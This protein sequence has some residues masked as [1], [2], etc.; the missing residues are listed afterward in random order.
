MA[1]SQAGAAAPVARTEM[2]ATRRIILFSMALAALASLLLLVVA[3][4]TPAISDTRVAWPLLALGFALADSF[5]VHVEVRD[6]AHSFTM[7]ELPLMIGLFLCNADQL[8]LARVVG[9]VVALVVVRRQRPLKALFNLALSVLETAAALLVFLLVVNAVGHAT[10]A[11]AWVAAILAAVVVNLLQSAAI[12]T[13][14]RLA[15]GPGAPGM[16][17]R[18]AVIGL[19]TAVTTASLGIITVIVIETDVAGV[20]LIG[21]I[22]GLMFAAYRGY[23][24]QSQRYANLEKLYELTRKLANSPDLEDSMRVTLQEARQLVRSEESELVLFQGVDDTG[25]AVLVRLTSSGELQMSSD[26][27]GGDDSVRASVVATRNGVVIPRTTHD[28]A[29]RAYL[30]QRGLVDLVTVPVFQGGVIVGTLA[31]HNRLGDVSSFDEEDAKVF[32]TLAHHVGTAIENARLIER[33]RTEV[34]QKEYQSLHDTLTGLGN[35]D[36]FVARTDDALRASRT[37][38]WSVAVMLMDLNR[39]K[40]V[41][42]TL[43]HHH[44]DLLLQQVARRIGTVLPEPGMIARLGGDEFV[45]LLPQIRNQE[46]AEQIAI[47]IQ[48]ALQQ[49]F[50]VD[51]MQLAVTAAIGIAVAPAHGTE[52]STLLQHADIAMYNAKEHGDG[53]V[54]VYD[55]DQNRHSTRRLTLAAELQTAIADGD[56]EV[57]YQ[58]KAVLETG[59]LVGVEALVRWEHPKH[60]PIPPDEFVPLAEGTGQ[61]RAMTTLVV[62]RVLQQ[63]GAWRDAGVD[64]QVSVNLSVRSLIDLDFASQI[65]ALCRARGVDPSALVLEITET[66][67][68]ADPTR[69]IRMLERLASLGIEISVDDFGTGYSSLSYLQRLP[70]HEIKVDK[71]FV[72]GMTADDAN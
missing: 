3:Q 49:P 39:F 28:L 10:G 34:S 16:A 66:Q 40:D 15:G 64:L 7:N 45:V 51:R 48:A 8:V 6:N 52:V 30:Q 57:Y 43:G 12:T 5:A 47:G 59:A 29:Q 11:G 65:D 23:A 50:V 54:E 36:L 53:G 27:L 42:D 55:P 18:M 20:F 56:L 26:E 41:N 63:V 4:Q 69:T 31:A 33:L 21:A 13:V 24:V 72:L 37:G 58:P 1:A 19:L 71:S 9:M 17:T 2:T 38:G 22:A 61:M 35:R 62:D 14:I 25:P 46:Q 60:G 67:M 70:V 32:A 44:G 68:M